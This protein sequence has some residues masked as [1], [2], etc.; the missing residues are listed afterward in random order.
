M[1]A[2]AAPALAAPARAEGPRRGVFTLVPPEGVPIDLALAPIGQRFAA[3]CVDLALT[4]TI[5]AALV[6]VLAVALDAGGTLVSSVLMLAFLFV[7]APYYV[8]AELLSGGRTAGKRW[9][10][11]RVVAVDGRALAPTAVV[12]RNL[13]KEAE[14][15]VPATALLLLG[16][17]GLVQGTVTLG[18]IAAVLTIPFANR[19]RQRLGDLI[20][21]TVVVAE[22]RARLLPE[23]AGHAVAEFAFAPRQ[24]DHYGAYELQTLETVLRAPSVSDA[25]LEA[26]VERI[27][28]RIDHVEPVAPDARRRFL[29]AF[30]AAQRAR[31]EERQLMG[32][33]RADK[34]HRRVPSA[35]EDHEERGSHP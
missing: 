15:F 19:R 7:R 4:L 32:E 23:L 6:L 34:H 35:A 10:G 26:V 11:L 14:V 27:R 25:T 28:A 30:Y 17:V 5:A 1:S 24:L 12:A 31:L 2:R 22:P 21:G 16:S 9:L 33:R 8:L 20:A 18:W 13:M 3:Q 29:T